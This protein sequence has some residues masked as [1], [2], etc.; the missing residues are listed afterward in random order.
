VTRSRY[1]GRTGPAS[2]EETMENVVQGIEVARISVL[3]AR[4]RWA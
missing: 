3:V 1:S 2:F 4:S